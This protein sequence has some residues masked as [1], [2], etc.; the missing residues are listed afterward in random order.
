MRPPA[1]RFSRSS[2]ADAES[3]RLSVVGHK[4]GCWNI[5]RYVQL[6]VAMT[7]HAPFRAGATKSVPT[8]KQASS[9]KKIRNAE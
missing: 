8:S 7:A 6:S 5:S 1:S 3:T 9:P 2:L 4:S